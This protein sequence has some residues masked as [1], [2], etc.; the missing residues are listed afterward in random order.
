MDLNKI[1]LISKN[2]STL[3]ISTLASIIG[4][5]GVFLIITSTV[6]FLSDYASK[7]DLKINPIPLFLS[8][9]IFIFGSTILLMINNLESRSPDIYKAYIVN[10]KEIY[11]EQKITKDEYNFIK[12][13]KAKD[14]LGD[15]PTNKEIEK[16]KKILIKWSI[17]EIYKN[18]TS[19]Y[20]IT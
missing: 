2:S 4:I 9:F 11:K 14:Q 15:K 19:V 17:Y 16:I 13:V 7:K 1:I 18:R 6:L 8:G 12:D 5:I 3:T 20:N 10:Q